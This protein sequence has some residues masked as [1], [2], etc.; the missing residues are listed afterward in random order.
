MRVWDVI[1]AKVNASHVRKKPNFGGVL[2]SLGF[3]GSPDDMVAPVLLSIGAQSLMEITHKGVPESVVSDTGPAYIK[4]GQKPGSHVVSKVLANKEPV[5]LPYFEHKEDIILEP[6][7]S[8]NRDIVEGFSRPETQIYMT[9]KIALGQWDWVANVDSEGYAHAYPDSHGYSIGWGHF[10]G[11]EDTNAGTKIPMQEA[12]SLFY[13]DMEKEWETLRECVEKYP[14]KAKHLNHV[15]TNILLDLGHNMGRGGIKT[16][17]EQWDGTDESAV[18]LLGKLATKS[19]ITPEKPS[20]AM[21]K[22]EGLTDATQWSS[23]QVDTWTKKKRKIEESLTKRVASRQQGWINSADFTTDWDLSHE[24]VES[25]LAIISNSYT[26]ADL[27]VTSY[28]IPNDPPEDVKQRLRDLC[29][30]VLYPLRNIVGSLPE[31]NSGYRCKELNASVRGSSF[32]QHMYGEAVDIKV[33]GYTPCQLAQAIIDNGIPYDQLI[34][35]ERFIHISFSVI[36]ATQR[37]QLL[38]GVQDGVQYDGLM[39]KVP[40]SRGMGSGTLVKQNS[41]VAAPGACNVSDAFR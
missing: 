25:Q 31:I 4:P 40:A 28:R 21:L 32:S 19:T 30:N 23:K 38:R 26:Y 6:G 7:R 12:W 11:D 37:Y 29:I 15:R 1:R 10:L 22:Q 13:E 9:P 39:P 33:P 5:R 14:E 3:T 16:F 35:Y 34:V 2:R 36:R 41:I 8:L 17:F 27:S 24:S 18:D 20:A